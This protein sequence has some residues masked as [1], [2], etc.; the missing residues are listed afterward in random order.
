MAARMAGVHRF[1]DLIAWQLEDELRREV[2][3]FTE[4]GKA[5]RDFKYRDQIRDAARG[6]PEF[7]VW[8]IA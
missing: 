6:Y 4:D 3:A 7:R 8:G 1:E 2:F 5:A